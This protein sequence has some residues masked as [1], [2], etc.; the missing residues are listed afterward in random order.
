MRWGE[1]LR[2]GAQTS[3]LESVSTP[4]LHQPESGIVQPPP[5]LAFPGPFFFGSSHPDHL[6]HPVPVV[7][8]CLRLRL[9]LESRLQGRP[10]PAQGPRR[11]PGAHPLLPPPPPFAASPAPGWWLRIPVPRQTGGGKDVGQSG[12]ATG[13][14]PLQPGKWRGWREGWGRL[15]NSPGFPNDYSQCGPGTK[16]RSAGVRGGVREPYACVNASEMCA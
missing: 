5:L 13:S 7:W 10:R 12:T 14:G 1:I 16:G 9:R 3:R 4:P 8:F 15:R 6:A 11:P 2:H